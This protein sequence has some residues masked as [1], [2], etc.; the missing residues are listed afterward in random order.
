MP[1]LRSASGDRFD[2]ELYDSGDWQ[3]QPDRSYV[4]L[5]DPDLQISRRQYDA[6][7]GRLADTGLTPESLAQVNRVLTTPSKVET[8]PITGR[9]TARF[10]INDPRTGRKITNQAA[11]QRI[12]TQFIDKQK[13]AQ[14]IQIDAR[15]KVKRTSPRSKFQPGDHGW[16]NLMPSQD[17]LDDAQG[18]W[19]D[20]D[21]M[22]NHE[23]DQFSDIDAIYV[24]WD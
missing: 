2:T 20:A 16:R 7:Y 18:Y 5:Y 10:D 24:S 22:Q 9:T 12:Q 8:D 14:N 6:H 23:A 13:G 1:E 21:D 19:Q 17:D 4:N 3:R 15:G 11:I